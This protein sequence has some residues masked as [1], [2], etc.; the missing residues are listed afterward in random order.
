MLN[1]QKLHRIKISES[2]ARIRINKVEKL[3]GAKNVNR[4]IAFAL[5]LLGVNRNN[6]SEMLSMP[7]GTLFSFLDRFSKNG[8][9]AFE[10][11]RSNSKYI[12]SNKKNETKINDISKIDINLLNPIQKKAF[13]LTLAENKMITRKKAGKLLK[14]SLSH[15]DF[16]INKI[17]KED[18]TCLIDKRQGQLSDYVF[19]PDIKSE[20]IIQFAINASISAKTSGMAIS[21]DLKKRIN[22]NLSDRSIR[23]HLSKLGLTNKSDNMRQLISKK[24]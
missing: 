13:I 12:I 19:T 9:K 22:I 2:K 18:L 16:L 17:S 11:M 10:D 8:I 3:I 15:I 4:I 21:K 14:L 20:I 23:L 5:Y 7:K 1:Y 6:I 24:N